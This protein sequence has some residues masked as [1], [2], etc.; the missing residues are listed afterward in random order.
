MRVL[1]A[2]SGLQFNCDFFP[3]EL[4]SRETTHPIFHLSQKKLISFTSKWANGE[5][6]NTDSYLLFLALFNSTDLVEWNVP[7][8]RT[9]MTDTIVATNMEYLI[10]TVGQLNLIKTP[11][12]AVPKFAITSET[13]SLDNSH[14]WIKAWDDAIIEFKQGYKSQSDWT[15][16]SNRQHALDKLIRNPSKSVDSYASIL[17][18]WAELAGDF[19]QYTQT[20]TTNFGTLT[21]ADYWKLIIKRCCKS[22]SIFQIP[23]V[24][25]EELIEH[26][27]MNILHGS[28]YSHELMKLLRMGLKKQSAFLGSDTNTNTEFVIL[29][30]DNNV[31]DANKLALILS[32]PTELPVESAYNSRLDFLKAK[33]KYD[34]RLRYLK[35]LEET[36]KLANANQ[37]FQTALGEL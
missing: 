26:C 8:I 13:K 35:G 25:L 14:Y 9:T 36:A 28:N 23:R 3:A 19:P 15:H 21:I 1:C 18:D 5:L 12:F 16:L 29:D 24:D 32:A 20:T 27:E 17:A 7:V 10:Q 2:I 22:E 33:L 30:A 11:S 37:T 34:M 6:T 4:T 31:E